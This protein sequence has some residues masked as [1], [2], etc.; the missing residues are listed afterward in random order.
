MRLSRVKQIAKEN[1]TRGIKALHQRVEPVEIVARRSPGRRLTERAECRGLAKMRIGDEER[2]R[3]LA[4]CG[5]LR[6]Q[7]ET[8]ILVKRKKSGAGP[9][10]NAF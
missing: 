8:A 1:E 10:R 6:Q 4:P 2:A 5:A 3:R 7:N 9:L